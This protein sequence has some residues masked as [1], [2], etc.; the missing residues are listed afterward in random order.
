MLY[1]ALGPSSSPRNQSRC[2][3]KDSGTSSG[4]VCADKAGRACSASSSRF[5]R[6]STDGAS[7]T[8]RTPI[9]TPRADRRRLTRRTARRE[10]PP[11]SKKLSST[12]T[13]GTLR[14]S[15]NTEHRISSWALAG[16]RP[17]LAAVYSGAGSARRS[18]L[19]LTVR[20]RV[21][22]TIVADGTMYSGSDRPRWPRS[23]DVSTVSPGAAGTTYATRRLSP[24]VSSRTSTA[25]C[26]IS[27]CD[28][29]AVSISPSSM[30]KPRSLTWSSA[31]PRYSRFPS[32]RQRTTSPVRYM[33]SPGPPKGLA[34]NRSA[35][36]PGR[37]RYPR[38]S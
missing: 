9:S 36:R 24:G 3:A 26:A 15:A 17:E 5:S 19:P 32:V 7:N 37:P 8:V 22:R 33:R 31:R 30:R 25:A 27:L 20:G 29:S 11:S 18:S 38:A 28:A 4:R 35:V 14:M 2:W 23:A 13:W 1:V 21:S 34:T 16:A 10:C 12:F 6:D